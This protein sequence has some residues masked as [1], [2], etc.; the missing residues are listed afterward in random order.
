MMKYV[1][2]L[3]VVALF[4]SASKVETKETLTVNVTNIEST[5]GNIIVAIYNDAEKGF[6][7]K[8]VYTYK[9][10]KAVK[11]SV[12]VEF[13]LSKGE[14]AV[15]VF[16]DEN[17]NK[18]LDSNMMHIPKEPYGFSNNVRMPKYDKAV[19]MIDGDKTISIKIDK[20]M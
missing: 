2:L 9:S 12:K 3:A 1:F 4:S 17:N 6:K 5:D 15:S 8:D 14:Y 19:F 11:G 16:H 18:E 7:T 10:V 20:F 13:Q